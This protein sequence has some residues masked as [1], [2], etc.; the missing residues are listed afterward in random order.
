[1]ETQGLVV[2]NAQLVSGAASYRSAGIH[3]YIVNLLRQLKSDDNLRYL[4]LTG[5]GV[6]PEGI[7][8]PVQRTKLPTHRP[9]IRIL[10]GANQTTLG[11]SAP[12]SQLTACAR[13]CRTIMGAL[14]A[15]SSPSLISALRHPNSFAGEPHL[16]APANTASPNEPA[17]ITISKFSAQEISALTR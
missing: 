14:P 9:L 8:V 3:A 6:L 5:P 16:F 17:I 11:A 10:S 13:F 12:A 2:L 7:A 1:M 15:R 4:A